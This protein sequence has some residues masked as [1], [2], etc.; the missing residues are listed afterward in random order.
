ME[1]KKLQSNVLSYR[2]RKVVYINSGLIDNTNEIQAPMI[3]EINLSHGGTVYEL[4]EALATTIG[5]VSTD[6]IMYNTLIFSAKN[7]T[8]H[9]VFQNDYILDDVKGLLYIC[10][11]K[12]SKKYVDIELTNRYEDTKL[13]FGHPTVI[14]IARDSLSC[15]S[16]LDLRKIIKDGITPFIKNHDDF[17]DRSLYRICIM[18]ESAST[19]QCEIFYDRITINLKKFVGKRGGF[20]ISLLW[21]PLYTNEQYINKFSK[22]LIQPKAITIHNNTF[23]GYNEEIFLEKDMI[24]DFIC[25]ICTEIV[26]NPIETQCGHLMCKICINKLIEKEVGQVI[27]CPYNCGLLNIDQIKPLGNF[28]K[29]IIL[30]LDVKCIN[31]SCTWK[32]TFKK[33]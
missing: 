16:L 26:K 23:G 19:I 3:Y 27:K 14:P 29:R 31:Q 7:H 28:T 6:I 8:I 33:L 15:I 20:S 32:G 18:D 10:E 2:K 25:V 1:Q 30:N 5:N 22:F 13:L 17:D 11:V 9:R 12:S 21:N 4:K 24:K